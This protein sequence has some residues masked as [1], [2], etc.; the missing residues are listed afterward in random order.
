MNTLTIKIYNKDDVFVTQ[1]ESVAVPNVNENIC[2]FLGGIDSR[3]CKGKVTE[4]LF[5]ENCVALTIDTDVKPLSE[6]EK[7]AHKW[8]WMDDE[9]WFD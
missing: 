6:Y 4:R 1:Y 7:E 3:Y 8:A 9:D 2:I 5:G